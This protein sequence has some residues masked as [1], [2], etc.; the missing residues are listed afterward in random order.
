MQAVVLHRPLGDNPPSAQ[1]LY[2]V[3]VVEG[4]KLLSEAS[5]HMACT[6]PPYWGLRDYGG[7]EGQVGIEDT[8]EAYIESLVEAFR[9]L[10]R[11]LRPD[12]TLWLN[13]GDSYANDAKWGGRTSGKHAQGLHGTSVGRRKQHSGLKPKDLAGIPWR[14][15]L[16]LQADGWYLR[17]D[18]VWSKPNPMPESVKDR[19][20]KSHEYIFL[21]AHPESGGRYYFDRDAVR[22]PCSPGSVE[23][24]LRRG[25]MDNKGGGN[26][27]YD[28]TR[29]DLCRD[30]SAYMPDDYKRNRRTV[31]ET[32]PK[33]YPG[34]HF[35]VWPPE[36]A[37]IMI[38]A[39]S[40]K[41]GTVLDPF[42]GSGT[43][44]MVALKHD[45][46]YIGI[47]L[48]EDYL[49]LAKRRILGMA[50]PKDAEEAEGGTLDIFGG[51]S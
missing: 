10:K 46:H 3:H 35:A 15:A 37:E 24:F 34:A 6:S 51:R 31:W 5:V 21:F 32:S 13:L 49:E 45:R 7:K 29:P 39:G 50:A 38:K 43:T 8:P 40:P 36:L 19:F 48:N 20:T 9:A 27:S 30:R 17:N 2:G 47:D 16:A 42:S 14:V 12:G 25:K 23:T 26:K 4:L 11:V 1:L 33:P 22:E 41:G 28:A 18:I 44:G